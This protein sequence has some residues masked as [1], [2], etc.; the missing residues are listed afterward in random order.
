MT[1]GMSLTSAL[2][3][4]K[5]AFYSLCQ[6]L[7]PAATTDVQVSYGHPGVSQRPDIIAL[8]DVSSQQ[9]EA[10]LGNLRSREETLTL[11]VVISCFRAGNADN[12]KVP[13]DAAIA[14]LAQLENAIRPMS[15]DTTLGGVVR[16][17]GL[18]DVI[19]TGY[20]DQQSLAH[21]RTIDLECTF[22][23]KCRVT[24]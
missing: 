4:Y 23:A 5:D 24:S 14:F 15:G 8:M 3:A 16:E 2:A 6:T 12:D 18:T 7:W 10:N 20:T 11:K 22:T 19:S 17:C 1:S 9:V 13:F 21:G